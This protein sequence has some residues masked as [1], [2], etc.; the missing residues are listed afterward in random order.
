MPTQQKPREQH[1]NLDKLLPPDRSF[2]LRG[3]I[4]LIPGEIDIDTVIRGVQLSSQLRN[5]VDLESD[6]QVA[7]LQELRT[8]VVE[9]MK[10]A[11]P[12]V[13]VPVF[14]FTALDYIFGLMMGEVDTRA[15]EAAIKAVVI[16]G[17][18]V[19]DDEG[20]VVD[21]PPTPRRARKTSAGRKRKTATGR[22]R[23]R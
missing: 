5:T 8:I 2:E 14:T 16:E 17:G 4:Y 20:K 22:R 7:L 10:L 9:Q 18:G 15:E 1:L 23:K 12:D 19:T 6:E 3:K 13:E 11:D 21:L